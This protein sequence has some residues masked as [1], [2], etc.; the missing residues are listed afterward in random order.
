MY[1]YKVGEESVIKT[2]DPAHDKATV[3]PA[4]IV[5]VLSEREST[6]ELTIWVVP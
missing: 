1:D 2:P 6:V 4:F 3:F 5:I